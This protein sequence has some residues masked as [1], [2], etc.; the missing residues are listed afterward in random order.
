MLLR[1]EKRSKLNIVT[2]CLPAITVAIVNV[3]FNR[4]GCL[5]IK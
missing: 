3:T 4:I 1:M 2:I 5:C